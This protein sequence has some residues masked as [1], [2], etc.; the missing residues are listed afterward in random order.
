VA[1][2]G[3]EPWKRTLAT[4]DF[5]G[6]RKLAVASPAGHKVAALQW[7]VGRVGQRGWYELAGYWRKGLPSGRAVDVPAEV[8]WASSPPPRAR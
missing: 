1:P 5:A 4:A 2:H 6:F 3:G 8:F 7:R